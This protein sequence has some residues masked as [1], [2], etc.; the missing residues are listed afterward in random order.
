ME[1]FG[2]QTALIDVFE[3]WIW[4][5]LPPPVSSL[6]IFLL[7]VWKVEALPILSSRYMWSKF[8]EPKVLVLLFLFLFHDNME[9]CVKYLVHVF[10]HLFLPG[11]L[12]SRLTYIARESMRSKKGSRGKI[13]S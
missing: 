8:Q 7:S 12:L 10:F 11:V 6:L 1:N 9:K 4:L 2:T 5:R 3:I 13:N